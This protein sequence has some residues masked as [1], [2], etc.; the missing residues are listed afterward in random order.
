MCASVTGNIFYYAFLDV[1][2]NGTKQVL[3]LVQNHRFKEDK[4]ESRQLK[5]AEKITR[6]WKSQN[7]FQI[8]NRRNTKWNENTT[9][10]FS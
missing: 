8:G 5:F 2:F 4:N 7:S 9:T 10:P 3:R 6:L 1:E